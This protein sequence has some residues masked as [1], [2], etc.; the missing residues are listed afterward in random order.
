MRILAGALAVVLLVAPAS[1]RPLT[2]A[3]IRQALIQQSLAS[4]PGNCPCPY[5]VDRRGHSCGRRSAYSRRGGYA[6]ICYASD[7]TP[8]MVREYH[9]GSGER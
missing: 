9:Q 3:E 4:Y 8:A 6:P 5:N 1:A 7:V 2:D